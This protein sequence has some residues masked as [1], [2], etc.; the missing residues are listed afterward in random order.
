[1][2]HPPVAVRRH[3]IFK[4]PYRRVVDAANGFYNMSPAAQWALL[5]A[6]LVADAASGE[7]SLLNVLDSRE[8]RRDEV[9]ARLEEG[10]RQETT[11]RRHGR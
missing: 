9:L 10:H 2:P 1:M 4:K 8:A 5:R 7:S 6:Q 11:D 3:A